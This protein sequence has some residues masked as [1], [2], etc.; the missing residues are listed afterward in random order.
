MA[1]MINTSRNDYSS[2]STTTTTTGNGTMAG[3]SNGTMAGVSVGRVPELGWRPWL[4]GKS[5]A[6]YVTDYPISVITKRD[7]EHQVDVSPMLSAPLVLHN[8]TFLTVRMAGHMV[9][10]YQP[11]R[12]LELFRRWL[13]NEPY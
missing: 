2:T 4:V 7:T 12:A 10:Q 1:S 5:V 11:A 8:F 3:V 9:P 6:G 13:H